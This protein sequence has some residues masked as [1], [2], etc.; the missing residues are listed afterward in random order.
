MREPLK[1]FSSAHV[2]GSARI[3]SLMALLSLPP[4]E[5]SAFLRTAPRPHDSKLGE[6]INRDKTER[7]E[8]ESKRQGLMG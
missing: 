7:K 1:G 8:E 4:I 2:F 6:W 5:S 3:L